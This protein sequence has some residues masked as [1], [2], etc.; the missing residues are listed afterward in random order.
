MDISNEVNTCMYG[1]PAFIIIK[2]GLAGGL[3]QNSIDLDSWTDPGKF[4]GLRLARPELVHSQRGEV[5]DFLRLR[6]SHHQWQL[7]YLMGY[8]I[9]PI[10][11]ISL[12]SF[13]YFYFFSKERKKEKPSMFIMDQKQKEIFFYYYLDFNW[14]LVALRLELSSHQ[15]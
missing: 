10:Q 6:W 13:C 5:A 15:L 2:P 11:L 4:D 12:L 3:I 8:C 14:W 7:S 9:K 1:S